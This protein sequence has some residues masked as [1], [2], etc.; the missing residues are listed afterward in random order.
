MGVDVYFDIHLHNLNNYS[1]SDEIFY[2]TNEKS[3]LVMSLPF[4]DMPIYPSNVRHTRLSQQ[5]FAFADLNSK[6]NRFFRCAAIDTT[7]SVH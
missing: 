2:I 7:D 1:R 4:R 5:L 6:M 3:A